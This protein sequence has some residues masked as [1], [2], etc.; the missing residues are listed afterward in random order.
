[1]VSELV[2]P[3]SLDRNKSWH[4]SVKGFADLRD[5][6]QVTGAR[7][8]FGKHLNVTAD[9]VPELAAR[10]MVE[11]KRARNAFAHD[12]DNAMQFDG[13][14]ER[15]LAVVCHIAFLTTDLNRISVYP[16]EDH[17]GEFEPQTREL[18]R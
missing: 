5:G 18:L 7:A 17:M 6:V 9:D 8:A 4:E 12:A 1:M 2:S 3:G 13:F 16:W 11:L 15:A 14:L 10:R